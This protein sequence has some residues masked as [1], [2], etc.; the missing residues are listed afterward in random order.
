[1]RSPCTA[2]K[3]SPHLPQLEN[4]RAATK[5]QCSHTYIH[6]FFFLSGGRT[7]EVKKWPT[8]IEHGPGGD[9]EETQARPPTCSSIGP[10]VHSLTKIWVYVSSGFSHSTVLWWSTHTLKYPGHHV[11]VHDEKSGWWSVAHSH[12]RTPPSCGMSW[13]CYMSDLYLSAC[14]MSVVYYWVGQKVCSSFS[15][16]SFPKWTFW[17]TQSMALQRSIWQNPFNLR[18]HE[19]LPNEK[20]YDIWIPLVWFSMNRMRDF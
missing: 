20:N 6:K 5:T 7:L 18:K 1:M 8:C 16:T 15:I 19:F 12:H 13:G 14:R 3:C 10:P 2:M 4:A 17:P 11:C 9:T